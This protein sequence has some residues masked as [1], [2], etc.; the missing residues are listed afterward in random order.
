MKEKLV[1][2]LTWTRLS[3]RFLLPHTPGMKIISCCVSRNETQ[4]SDLLLLPNFSFTPLDGHFDAVW[5]VAT[6]QPA[7]VIRR[8]NL[9][10]PQLHLMIYCMNVWW[11]SL[12]CSPGSS[13]ERCCSHEHVWNLRWFDC[14][15]LRIC[16]LLS[17][18]FSFTSHYLFLNLLWKSL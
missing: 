11:G 4:F 12:I 14:W 15:I 9:R 3:L 6:T 16:C 10:S 5:S 17:P 8:V 2:I 13:R 7:D 1:L 18:F